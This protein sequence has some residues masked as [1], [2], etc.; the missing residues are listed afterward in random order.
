[1]KELKSN[2]TIPPGGA[3]I[4]PSE[5]EARYRQQQDETEG[6]TLVCFFVVWQDAEGFYH[7]KFAHSIEL[8][9]QDVFHDT[10]FK[11]LAVSASV[12]SLR[13]SDGYEA[14]RF[15]TKAVAMFKHELEYPLCGLYEWEFRRETYAL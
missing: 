7:E 15:K 14:G 12:Q 6:M 3:Y 11:R 8:C 1:M 2:I 5:L 10:E 4:S 13:V 9:D